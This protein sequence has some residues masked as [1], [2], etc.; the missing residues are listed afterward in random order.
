[1][2]ETIGGLSV[3]GLRNKK[4]QVV[5]Y[6]V[7]EVLLLDLSIQKEVTK[8]NLENERIFDRLATK[9]YC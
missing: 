9:D 7:V 2:T 8:Q 4:D 6:L 3:R 5:E 1:M